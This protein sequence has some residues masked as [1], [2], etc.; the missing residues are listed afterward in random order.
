MHE[1]TVDNIGENEKRTTISEAKLKANRLNAS[2]ST[3]P[4]TPDGKRRSSLNAL[5]SGVTGQIQSL[6][7]EDLAVYQKQLDEIL[8]EYNPVGPTE[9]FYA[10]SIAENMFRISRCR[11]LENGIFANGFR[12]HIDSIDAGHP[13]VDASLAAAR[14][15]EEQGRQIA[16]LSVYEGRMRRTLE[17]DLAALKALQVE[18][19][20]KYEQAVDQ[21]T[22]FARYAAKRNEEYDP[23][24][25][26]EAASEW[27]GFVFSEPEILARYDRQRR[28]ENARGYCRTGKDPRPK[29]QNDP[30]IDMAA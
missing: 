20:E 25:D 22:A 5:R 9:R 1:A 21:A 4:K 23:G 7:A 30:K 18:R 2:K 28:Y 16:L 8:A 24:D 6:P 3:G 11:A 14:T 13:E 12:Q 15:F 19:K 26:F 27:G 17:K 10:S 29:P